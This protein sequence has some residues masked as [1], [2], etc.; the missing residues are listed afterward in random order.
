MRNPP[1]APLLI[2]SKASNFSFNT[3][4]GTTP[5]TRLTTF[6]SLKNDQVRNRGY[7]IR[8]GYARIFI[9]IDLADLD[10]AGI[11]FGQVGDD[12]SHHLAR[13]APGGPEVQQDRLGIFHHLGLKVALGNF[14]RQTSVSLLSFRCAV[15]GYWEMPFSLRSCST[16]YSGS[17]LQNRGPRSDP[18]TPGTYSGFPLCGQCGR[19]SSPRF[20]AG[21]PGL[22]ELFPDFHLI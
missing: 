2:L 10:F 12:R 21:P 19:G 13:A 15:T 8:L 5:M 14:F 16:A 4:S 1:P 3:L 17:T 22:F 11:F 9:D 6:P 18:G 7:I 20:F